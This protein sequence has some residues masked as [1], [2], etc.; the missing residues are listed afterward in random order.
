MLLLFALVIEMFEIFRLHS[1]RWRFR[2]T[3]QTCGHRL[4]SVSIDLN[5]DN[6][7][8]EHPLLKCDVIDDFEKSDLLFLK[9]SLITSSFL[10]FT[11]S[12]WSRGLLDS[13]LFDS[14]PFSKQ[15][16]SVLPLF[17]SWAAFLLRFHFMRRFWNQILTF[18]I[19]TAKKEKRTNESEWK[20]Q[21]QD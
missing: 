15:A 6:D 2:L 9:F 10:S 1:E 3:G 18:W 17:S 21:K 5:S 13:Y 11:L 14:K 7:G 16:V 8:V 19:L 20:G 12:P 4:L